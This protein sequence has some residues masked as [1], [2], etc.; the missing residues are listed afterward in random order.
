M[1]S[2]L[3]KQVNKLRAD[4]IQNAPLHQGRASLFLDP[5]EAAT[6]DIETIYDT[7][8]NA[9]KTLIQYDDR[10][11]IFM[12]TLL[13]PSSQTLQRELKTREVIKKLCFQNN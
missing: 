1:T 2:I 4:V 12:E 3:Q 11:S 5:N 7:A 8:F 10:F 9:L 6:L 13:H